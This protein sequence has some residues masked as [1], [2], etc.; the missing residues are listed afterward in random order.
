M[1]CV[2][3]VR[4]TPPY[5]CVPLA[6]E[7]CWIANGKALLLVLGVPVALIILFNIVALSFTMVAIWKVQKVSFP[8][9][10]KRFLR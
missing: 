3:L 8:F 5:Y 2:M 10:F 9:W 4:V 6:G 7:F 1:K